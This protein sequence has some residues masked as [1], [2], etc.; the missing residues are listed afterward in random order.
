MPSASSQ[1]CINRYTQFQSP[2]PTVRRPHHSRPPPAESFLEFRLVIRGRCHRDT[3]TAMTAPHLYSE[4]VRE[5]PCTQ[6]VQME[7]SELHW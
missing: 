1:E 5:S 2:N 7:K 3:P 4:V 6:D